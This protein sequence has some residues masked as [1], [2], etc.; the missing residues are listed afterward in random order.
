MNDILKELQAL[1]PIEHDAGEVFSGK[2]SKRTV[3]GFA[4]AF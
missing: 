2:K 4:S 1:Q 3:P